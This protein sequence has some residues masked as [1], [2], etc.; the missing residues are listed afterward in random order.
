MRGFDA[1]LLTTRI[2][3]LLPEGRLLPEPAWAVR[4]RWIIATLWLH[5]AG[6]VVFGIARGYGVLHSAAEAALVAAAA[7]FAGHGAA[8]RRLRSAVASFGLVASSALL[9]HFWGG[10]I[11]AHFHFFFV[12][13]LLALYQD[14]LPFLLALV[15]VALHHGVVGAID[16]G[17]VY[18]HPGGV[19]DPWAW[20]GI[21]ALFICATSIANVVTWRVNEQLLRE[22]LTGLPGR[23]VFLD[24]LEQA[25][26][27][28][29]RRRGTVAVIFVDLDRFK[30]INDS[31]GHGTGDRL[32]VAVAH[33]LQ[34]TLR[35]TDSIARLGGDEFAVLCEDVPAEQG[36]LA[37]AQRIVDAV[38]EATELEGRSLQVSASVGIALTSDSA[39]S[40]ETLMRDADVAM[41][42]AKASGGDGWA[43]FD[44]SMHE[45]VVERLDLE[46]ALRGALERGE[47]HLDYQP[48]RDVA[49]GRL[50]GVEALLRWRHPTLGT[51]APDRFIPIAEDTGLIL[52]IGA[53]V[54]EEACRQA[55]RWR[56]LAPDRARL[57]MRVNLSPRQLSQ[58]DLVEVIDDALAAT[59]TDAAELDLELTE[60]ALMG[61]L[62]WARVSL[63]AL[64]TLGLRLSV[65]DFGTGHSSLSHLRALPFDTLKIDRSFVSRLGATPADD[66]IVRSI[67]DLAH[68]LELSVNA[69][70]VEL[71]HQ[72]GALK[73]LGCD[74]AQGF[75]LGRPHGAAEIS[76]LLLR[77]PVAA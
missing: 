58:P 31:M 33:R 19:D 5:A 39:A 10:V 37:L 32:L 38:G 3:A 18:N 74:T 34:R 26:A 73:A 66:E 29:D 30:L 25:L 16:P 75:L 41:Y 50:V 46:S 77:E 7:L 2:G 4:H 62:E 61:A 21:H 47:L 17:S 76:T 49:T 53:W 9:V 52:P 15:F 24:R 20:A 22:P 1:R 40:A 44:C 70:G 35:R 64:R 56:A 55:A 6:L 65:D 11:E 51:V 71:P 28:L 72:L 60:S 48:E 63:T 23:A 57:V 42:R 67:I 69:E 45:Q 36:V 12:V 8:G 13:G 27:R 43:L 68:A 54:I 14:W 59:G